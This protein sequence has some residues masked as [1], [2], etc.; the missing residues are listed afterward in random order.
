MKCLLMKIVIDLTHNNSIT[1]ISILHGF[2][3]II[4][5]FHLKTGFN[6]CVVTIMTIGTIK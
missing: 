2:V 6:N 5:L 3:K 4:H 1:N